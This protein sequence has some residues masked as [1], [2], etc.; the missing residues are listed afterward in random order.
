[1]LALTG[2]GATTL[3]CWAEQNC[4]EAGATGTVAARVASV[5]MRFNVPADRTRPK[6]PLSGT[7]LGVALGEPVAVVEALG[8]GECEALGD[9]PPH[10]TSRRAVVTR[11]ARRRI[12]PQL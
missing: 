8:L 10:E 6:L 3:S 11:V 12:P 7:A 9:D 1:L 2:G 4:A 5:L